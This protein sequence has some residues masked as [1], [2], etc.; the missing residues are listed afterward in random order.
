M[1]NND[2]F[3]YIDMK[4]TNPFGR[5][6]ARL[7]LLQIRKEI[8]QTITKDLYTDVD[9][10]NCHVVIPQQLCKK[11]KVQT[12][13]LDDY[14]NNREMYLE[15]LMTEYCGNFLLEGNEPD[16]YKELVAETRS[17]AKHITE[18]NP[19]IKTMVEEINDDV[20]AT[21]Q[22]IK[23]L[24]GKVLSHYLQEIEHVI[25]DEVFKYCTDKRNAKHQ[26]IVENNC[27]LQADGIMIPKA[28]F[29]HSLLSELSKHIKKKC[30]FYF[31]IYRKR[32]ETTLLRYRG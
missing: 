10:E 26:Y 7:S 24:N 1:I 19:D 8:R 18:E 30:W 29:K 23:N 5:S 9:I 12:P 14:I 3:I 25:L 6:H 13:K 27:S 31:E 11:N 15:K 21:H 20:N 22:Y 4:K 17:I 16:Y 28:N 2:G 32:N